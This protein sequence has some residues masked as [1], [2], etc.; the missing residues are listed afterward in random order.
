VARS[1]PWFW[2]SLSR[3]QFESTLQKDAVQLRMTDDR[4]SSKAA[5]FI[6]K[7]VDIEAVRARKN[8]LVASGILKPAKNVNNVNIE[9]VKAR[10]NAVAGKLP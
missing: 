10:K 2:G 5:P 9:D 1:N 3:Q 7:K 8:A 4:K 6:A